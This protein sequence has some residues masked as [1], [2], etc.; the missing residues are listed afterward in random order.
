[1]GIV[2]VCFVS[3]RLLHYLLFLSFAIFFLQR[4]R[5]ADYSLTRSA[6]GRTHPDLSGTGC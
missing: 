1:M 6:L 4:L 5:F 3:F 2:S